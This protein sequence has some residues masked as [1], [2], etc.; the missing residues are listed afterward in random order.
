MKDETAGVAMEEFLMIKYTSKT[1]D[2]IDQF[3]VIRVNYKETV[4]LIT[5][6]TRFVAKHIVL[7]F[8]LVRTAFLRNI[9]NL[10]NTK[11]LKK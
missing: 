3:L 8:S 7:I 11:H 4:I 1:K 6:Q 9:L 10:K 5:I 2:V